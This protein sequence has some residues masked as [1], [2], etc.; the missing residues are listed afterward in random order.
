MPKGNR[1]GRRGNKSM[2]SGKLRNDNV[3]YV[4]NFSTERLKVIKSG[5][6]PKV[7]RLD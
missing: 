2:T 4:K 5:T 7:T 3:R 6:K 1:G